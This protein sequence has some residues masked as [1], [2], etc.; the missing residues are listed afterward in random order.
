MNF[1]DV[2]F[3]LRSGYG[4]ERATFTKVFSS[5]FMNSFYVELQTLFSKSWSVMSKFY[6]TNRYRLT[7]KSKTNRSFAPL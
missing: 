5:I 1:I 2:N 3:K 6:F 4:F 7:A